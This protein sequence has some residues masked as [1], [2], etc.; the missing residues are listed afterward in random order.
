M[1]ARHL[2]PQ[3]RRE[4][5]LAERP[6]LH[7]GPHRRL[8]R[9]GHLGPHPGVLH[10]PRQ[11]AAQRRPPLV[12]DPA[13]RPQQL[14]EQ[15]TVG[16]LD[17][18]RPRRGDVG[19]QPGQIRGHLPRRLLVLL[20]VRHDRRPPRPPSAMPKASVRP[21]RRQVRTAAAVA[22]APNRQAHRGSPGCTCIGSPSRCQSRSV[23]TTS[24]SPSTPA[25]SAPSSC[26]D[27][28][29]GHAPHPDRSRTGL[30]GGGAPPPGT[31]GARYHPSSSSA[32]C[33]SALSR[34]RRL[35]VLETH[36]PSRIWIGCPVAGSTR[37][38]T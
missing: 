35:R 15:R 12:L 13:L 27:C 26:T 11:L 28:T 18:H 33:C 5:R 6:P 34:W 36:T 4:R 1:P 9:S 29:G 32:A 16:C 30:R 10:R 37:C 25:R 23:S 3:L 20:G 38:S 19:R 2:V 17:T 24:L 14:P 21:R 31:L 22:C 8:F 7:G